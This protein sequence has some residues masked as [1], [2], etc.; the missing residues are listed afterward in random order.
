MSYRKI[1]VNNKTYEYVIG[2][3]HIKIKDV[4]VFNKDN[5]GYNIFVGDKEH[6]MKR[7]EMIT[8][9]HI[10]QLILHGYSSNKAYYC[11]NHE[12]YKKPTMD[13]F[14]SEIYNKNVEERLCPKCYNIS[15]DDI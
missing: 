8:P 13:P 12:K 7:K 11:N 14:C 3:S 9:Y 4:G 15:A 10:K 5:V 6:R 2:K 1:T